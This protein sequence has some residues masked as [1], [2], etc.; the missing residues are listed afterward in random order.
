MIILTAHT[1]TALQMLRGLLESTEV[2]IIGNLV[3]YCLVFILKVLNESRNKIESMCHF[4]ELMNAGKT[5]KYDSH[6]HT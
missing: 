3:K 6:H 1:H 5:S 4:N 2:I